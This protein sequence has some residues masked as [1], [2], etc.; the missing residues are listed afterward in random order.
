MNSLPF[1]R[2]PSVVPAGGLQPPPYTTYPQQAYAPYG[3]YNSGRYGRSGM[4]MGTGLA[5]GGL[6]GLLLGSAI[7]GHHGFGGGYGYGG[8][9]GGGLGDTDNFGGGGIV[10]TD[11]DTF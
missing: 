6:G 11:T 8:G 4:G 7:G 5:A 10:S 9:Y 2:N 1:G 3:A